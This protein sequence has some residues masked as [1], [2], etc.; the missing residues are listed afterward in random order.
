[1]SHVTTA[2]LRAPCVNC[3]AELVWSYEQLGYALERL[4]RGDHAACACDDDCAVDARPWD[5]AFLEAILER[6]EDE[7]EEEIEWESDPAACYV[8]CAYGEGDEPGDCYTRIGVTASGEW[9]IDDGDDAVR[10]E[11]RGPYASREAALDAA[12]ELA[13]ERN[14]ADPGEDAEDLLARTREETAGDPDPDGPWC[15]WWDTS[16]DDEGPRERYA[17]REQAEARAELLQAELRA[18]QPGHLLCGH[19]VRVLVGGRWVDPD[20]EV[21]S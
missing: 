21:Q 10:V 18:S 15:V 2:A 5:R 13:D 9:W 6:E 17:T 11:S 19:T 7:D 14:E 12:I 1:M 8:V 16:L 3:G 20:E 4:Y